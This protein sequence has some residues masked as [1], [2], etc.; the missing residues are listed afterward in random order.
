MNFNTAALLIA[1]FKLLLFKNKLFNKIF[2]IYEYNN[3]IF[4]VDL[5]NK[6]VLDNNMEIIGIYSNNSVIFFSEIDS[7]IKSIKNIKNVNCFKY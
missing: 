5:Q 2:N 7:I 6:I 1:G 4:F 3:Q